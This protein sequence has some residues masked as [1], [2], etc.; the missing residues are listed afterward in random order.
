M[1]L[2]FKE[3]GASD[4][5]IIARIHFQSSSHV[6]FDIYAKSLYCSSFFVRIIDPRWAEY[7]SK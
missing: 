2:P 6:L 5:R 7:S 1:G 3:M 4:M